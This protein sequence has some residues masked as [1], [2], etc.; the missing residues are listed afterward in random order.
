MELFKIFGPIAL[1]ILSLGLGAVVTGMLSVAFSK[2]RLG[3]QFGLGAFA[4]IVV[5]STLTLVSVLGHR[6]R[7]ERAVEA[8]GDAD[9]TRLLEVARI[10]SNA[11]AKLGV[12]AAA[13]ALVLA[14]L[15]VVRSL[16]ATS[17]RADAPASK[18]KAEAEAVDVATLGDSNLG[19]G[20]LV[21]GCMAVFSVTASVMPLILKTAKNG[22]AADAPTQKFREAEKHLE[23]GELAEGCT[24][25]SEAWKGSSDPARA[26]G[27]TAPALVSECFEQNLE[28]ALNAPDAAER[29]R[30]LASLR[31][32]PL[33][34]S[35]DQKKRLAEAEEAA[36]AAH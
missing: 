18:K 1:A 3:A 23:V 9:R 22:I 36:K 12:A 13:I 28:R 11:L 29:D 33:P 14:I 15:G 10:Q 32:S 24:L 5:E 30:V 4:L 35:D 26:F 20:A 27:K 21:L 7:A 8:L 19:L 2:S 6:I 16:T 34:I 17:K 25:L 31:E